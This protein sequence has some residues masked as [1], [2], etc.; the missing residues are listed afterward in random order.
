MHA[1]VKY[2]DLFKLLQGDGWY[3]HHQTGSH[4]VLRHK[5]K[6]GIVVIAGG[7][8]MNREVPKGTENAIRRQAGLK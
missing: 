4:M 3:L 1:A 5:I 8:K 2:R 6:P 7:G